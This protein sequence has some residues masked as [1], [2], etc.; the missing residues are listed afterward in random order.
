MNLSTFDLSAFK[1][2]TWVF[3]RTWYENICYGK[4]GCCYLWMFIGW[5]LTLEWC[6]LKRLV[7]HSTV[8]G[9]E[10]DSPGWWTLLVLRLIGEWVGIV[11]LLS[12]CLVFP[13]WRVLSLSRSL[14]VR[15][16]GVNP[17]LN[18]DRDL[19]AVIFWQG[20]RVSVS[21]NWTRH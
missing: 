7:T 16:W 17:S 20:L 21:S 6:G 14:C 2:L 18:S 19:P 1:G 10:W 13:L 3:R 12:C 4:Y 9:K 8:L 15:Q 11:L 5:G